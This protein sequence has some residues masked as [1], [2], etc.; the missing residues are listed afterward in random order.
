MSFL[1]SPRFPTAIGLHSTVGVC[2]QTDIVCLQNGFEQ[3][4]AHWAFPLRRYE[5]TS[6]VQSKGELVEILT[7]F[8]TVKGRWRAFRFKDCLDDRSSSGEQGISPLDQILGQGDGQLCDF[9]LI[10]TLGEDTRCIQKPVPNTV[11]VAMDGRVTEVAVDYTTGRIHFSE[12]PE[13][14]TVIT[15]GFEFDVPCRFDTDQLAISLQSPHLGSYT[16]PLV[17]VRL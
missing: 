16:L 15:A 4:N 8:N 17:E 1:E 11:Q 12:P 2:F 6:G 14:G 13:L 9:Q 10:Q 3:R 5:V 7:F